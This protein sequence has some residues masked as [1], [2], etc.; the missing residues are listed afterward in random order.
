M[1]ILSIGENLKVSWLI[2]VLRKGSD[3]IVVS[4]CKMPDIYLVQ[5]LK[6]YLQ[7]LK[8]KWY[9]DIDKLVAVVNNFNNFPA[10]KKLNVI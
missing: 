6:H 2:R 3:K 5:I 8:D 10:A 1:L 4:D 7:N 9:E